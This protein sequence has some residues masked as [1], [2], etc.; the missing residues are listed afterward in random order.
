MTTDFRSEAIGSLLRP[1]YLMDAR[2]SSESG[3]LSPARFKSIEDRAVDEALALQE[4]AGIEVVTDGEM[5]RTIFTD[6]IMAVEGIAPGTGGTFVWRR[7]RD[8]LEQELRW[9]QPY[10]VV[11][12]LKRLRS[13]PNE[14]FAYA[15]SR[16]KRQLKV[17]LPSPMLLT[18]AWSQEHSAGSY[19][20]PFGLFRDGA[21]IIRQE[22]HDLAAL[23]CE[24]V[25]IDAPEFAESI[26][27]SQMVREFEARGV[28]LQR[29]VTEGVEVL[30]GLAD[31]PGVEFGLHMCR[32]NL[33]GHW[34]AEGGYE[35]ISKDVF[36]R[37]TRYGVLLLEYDDA[38]S[39]SFEPLKDIP[40]D[41]RV[42]LGLVSTKR[43][44][45][46]SSEEIVRRLDEAARFF[47]RDRLSLSPQCGFASATDGNPISE[48]TQKAKLHLIGEVA[49]RFWK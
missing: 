5:R 47:P 49:G 28:S 46:E 9:P 35:E 27:G 34:L 29:L 10:V 12:R 11:G 37:A 43:D 48:A 24:Y 18:M 6:P 45:L 7:K 2:A 21:E 38:R 44:T 25:Q 40:D 36:R 42:V 31:C 17:T 23:G 39:G 30:N 15:R 22:I 19:P 14:E 33:K 26:G 41:K 32:G 1:K 8:G 16:T 3:T 4:S 13:L 20:D